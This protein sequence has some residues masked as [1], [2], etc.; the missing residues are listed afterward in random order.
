MLRAGCLKSCDHSLQGVFE[1]KLKIS[2]LRCYV[3]HQD[4]EVCRA[5]A[6]V[7]NDARV[8]RRSDETSELVC[9]GYGIVSAYGLIRPRDVFRVI[10]GLTRV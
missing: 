4:H 7:W 8:R 1:A 9:G 10:D 2:G 6:R 5:S 3:F